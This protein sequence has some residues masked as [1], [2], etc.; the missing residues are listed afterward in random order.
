MKMNAFHNQQLF[1]IHLISPETRLSFPIPFENVRMIIKADRTFL[2][3]NLF[4]AY[5]ATSLELDETRGI[6]S[7]LT[8]QTLL[9]LR[10]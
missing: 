6:F 7:L 3:K 8:T 9:R 4:S 1:D 10:L 2:N 5:K